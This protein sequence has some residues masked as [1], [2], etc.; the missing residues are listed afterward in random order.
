MASTTV[1]VLRA[2]L[3]ADTSAFDAAMAGSSAK[4]QAWSADFTRLGVGVQQLGEVFTNTLSRSLTN[5]NNLARCP[6][7]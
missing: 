5:V 2:L 1:G 3:T 7:R 6:H 4:T